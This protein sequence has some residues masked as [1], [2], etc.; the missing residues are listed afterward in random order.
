MTEA[1]KAAGI[2]DAKVRKTTVTKL[3]RDS[4][5]KAN[6]VIATSTLAQGATL[7]PEGIKLTKPPGVYVMPRSML[8]PIT[9]ES[10]LQTVSPAAAA[11][12]GMDAF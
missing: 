12:A 10:N 8:K 5:G 11:V 3:W 7:P 6:P 2:T 9:E 4:A 1:L